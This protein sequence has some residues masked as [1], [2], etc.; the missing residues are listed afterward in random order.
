MKSIKNLL[1]LFLRCCV[2]TVSFFLLLLFISCNNQQDFLTETEKEWIQN[3]S[4]NIEILFGYN[5]PPNA[6]YNDEGEYEGFLVDFSKE[7]EKQLQVKIKVRYFNNWDELMAYSKT[8]KNFIIVGI[9]QSEERNTYLNFTNSFIR[10]PYVLITRKEGEI[11]GLD[12]LSSK[13]ICVVKNYAVKEFLLENYPN[14]K[15]FEVN[16]NYQGLREVSINTYDAFI[17]NQMYATYQIDDK[18]ISN[19]K[20]VDEIGYFNALSVAVPKGN[21]KLFNILNKTVDH[22]DEFRKK[23]IYNKW[24]FATSSELPKRYMHIILWIVGSV[25]FLML[26]LW[27]WLISLRKQV[28]IKTDLIKESETKY[29]KLIANSYDAIFIQQ[30][31][32]FKLVN[33]EF[34]SLFGYSEKELF[35]PNFDSS[36]LLDPNNL[37]DVRAKK[38]KFDKLKKPFKYELV[39]ISKSK[40][41]LFVEVSISYLLYGNSYAI[42]GIVHDITDRKI[43]EIELIKAKEKAEESD[44]LKS[45]FLANMSHEIRTPMNGILGFTE[46]LSDPNLNAD[47]R[48]NFLKIIK[49]SGSRML[50]TVNDLI[51]ISKIETNQ[52]NFVVSEVNVNERIANLFN[53]F[54]LE[55]AQKQLALN[56]T[57]GL[58]NELANIKTDKPKFDSI[59]SNLVKNALKFTHK[60]QIDFGYELIT[61]GEKE[62]LQFF[63]KDTGIGIPSNRIEAIFNRFEQA[64]IEDQLAYQGSGLGLTISKSYIEMQGGKIWVESTEGV[65][66]QFYFTLPYVNSL[67][68]NA[69]HKEIVIEK[70]NTNSSKKILIVEDDEI[71]AVYLNEILKNENAKVIHVKNGEDAIEFCKSN[72]DVD[73][74]L[75]DIKMHGI[76]GYEAAKEIRKFNKEIIIIAQTAFT[77]SEIKKKSIEVGC[78]DFILKPINKE[79]LLQKI[80]KLTSV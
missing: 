30:D 2:K 4:E 31:K 71:S 45:A 70:D 39:C 5:A 9:A 25:L 32:K 51:D 46:L 43:K 58:S 54:K 3:N 56:Y 52:M 47:K 23:E 72:A 55:A 11:Y 7:I 24:I 62:Y 15:P 50:N 27:L 80:K 35:A 29:R 41:K 26:A 17:T 38:E 44:R 33:K 49:Q 12:D 20:I 60:G 28:K 65:G 66:S 67:Q 53:F 42:Q 40:Q 13:K 22:I 36:Q 16:D 63:V 59:V 6:F 1:K 64:D 77:F 68:K 61:E 10:V 73:I 79:E 8:A 74:V 69:L 37:L 21:Q 78:N 48:H 75:M 57:V 14:L 76:N 34:V 19:L 18:G